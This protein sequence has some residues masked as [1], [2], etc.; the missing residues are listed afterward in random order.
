MMMNGSTRNL[1]LNMLSKPQSQ[2]LYVS[3]GLLGCNAAWRPV[4]SVMDKSTDSIFRTECSSKTLIFT[5]SLHGVTSKNSNINLYTAVRTSDHTKVILRQVWGKR[6]VSMWE[7]WKRKTGHIHKVCT[8][9]AYRMKLCEQCMEVS[10]QLHI[11]AISPEGREPSSW[12]QHRMGSRASLDPLRGK[13]WLCQETNFNCSLS[14]YW[15]SYMYLKHLY[16]MP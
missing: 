9:R 3:V 1:Q 7:I 13:Y 10:G 11:S 14:F 8:V 12:T 4:T 6:N 2:S 5:Y 16:F 15:L